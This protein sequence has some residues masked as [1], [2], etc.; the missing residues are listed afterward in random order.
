MDTVIEPGGLRRAGLVMTAGPD[1]AVAGCQSVLRALAASLAT[2]ACLIALLGASVQGARVA[3]PPAAA[4][5]PQ[6]LQAS[7][8]P[9]LS[10]AA[11]MLPPASSPA[12]LHDLSEAWL[13]SSKPVAAGIGA[14]QAPNPAS[15][16][17]RP[18]IPLKAPDLARYYLPREVDQPAAPLEHAA[19][20]YPEDAL[21]RRI[22][23]LVVMHVYIGS[24]G[25]IERTEVVRAEPPGVFEQAVREALE[26]SRFRPALLGRAPVNSR[27]TIE[28]PFDPD[29][30]DFMTCEKKNGA[31][32]RRQGAFAVGVDMS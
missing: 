10:Q 20:L 26:A 31:G 12:R 23:G 30:S 21:K 24:D 32:A 6:T 13:P 4:R 11:P 19:M 17:A 22:S 16:P 3:D 18:L 7:L 28:V 27:I 9:A 5:A 29:C 1:V 25:S 8:R 14:E 2:H 15:S